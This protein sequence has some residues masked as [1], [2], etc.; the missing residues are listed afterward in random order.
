MPA[1]RVHDRNRIVPS[2]LRRPLVACSLCLRIREGG[3]WIDAGRVIRR[4]R[5]FEHDKVV[6]LRGA[7]CED[8]ETELRRRRLSGTDEL[9]A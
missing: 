1:D 8:C 6:R 4:L 7:L 3:A 5:T 2:S 9:A